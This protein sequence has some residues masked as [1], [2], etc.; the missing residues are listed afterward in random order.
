[1]IDATSL[2]N[3]STPAPSTTGTT[4]QTP[5]SD[6]LGRDAFLRLLTTQLAHQDPVEPQPDGEFIAQLATFSSLEQLTSINK[7]V[8]SMAQFLGDVNTNIAGAPSA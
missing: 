1:V 8:T 4:S 6:N 5:R 2:I 3:G 7:A